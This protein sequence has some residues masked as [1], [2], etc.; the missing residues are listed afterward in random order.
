[1]VVNMKKVKI[2]DE[3]IKSIE[4]YLNSANDFAIK[5]KGLPS[6]QYFTGIM[7]GVAMVFK[8]FGI[9]C[10]KKNGVWHVG[11]SD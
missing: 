10:I 4:D 1:M 6:A 5:N 7:D 8:F 11:L 3:Q 2:T 9:S